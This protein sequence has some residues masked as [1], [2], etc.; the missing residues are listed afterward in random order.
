M[1][2]LVARLAVVAVLMSPAIAVAAD[3]VPDMKGR[4]VGKTYSIVAGKGASS[5]VS[6][7]EV[8][9]AR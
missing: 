6:Y 7:T 1:V 9:R 4:W 3:P 2:K 8:K 5:V